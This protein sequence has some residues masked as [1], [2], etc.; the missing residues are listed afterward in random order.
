MLDDKDLARLIRD[1]RRLL[2]EEYT[3]LT[4]G[5]TARAKRLRA[6][7]IGGLLARFFS[8]RRR[9]RAVA[10]LSGLDDRM[11]KD[12]GIHRSQIESAVREE[13]RDR[14]KVRVAA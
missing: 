14:A 1:Y 11:L 7:F 12:V 4:R 5:V 8:W 2:P 6:E 3:D 10:E 13:T 9:T